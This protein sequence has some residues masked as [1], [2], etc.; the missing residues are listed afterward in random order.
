MLMSRSQK[1]GQTYSIKIVNRSFEDMAKFKY[2][3]TTLTDQNHIHEE[4][5]SRL[6]PEEKRPVGRREDGRTGSKCT[7]RRLVG[8]V[9]WIDLA[10]DRDLWQALVNAVM[11]LWVLAPQS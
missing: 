3:G 9:E 10:R 4:I 6:K 2:L 11:I 7:L 5:N 8:G 1:T